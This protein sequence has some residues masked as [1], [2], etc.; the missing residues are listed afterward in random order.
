MTDILRQDIIEISF[1]VD[2]KPLQDIASEL[3]GLKK[4]LE[5]SIDTDAFDEMKESADE[6]NESIKDIKDTAKKA[7]SGLD[8]VNKAKFTKL[9]SGLQTIITKLTT[10]AKKA[11]GA[12]LTALK[13]VAG[14]SFK[15]VTAG[16]T[17]C[18]AAIGGLVTK[19]VQAY[20]DYEQLKGG[21]ETL[22]GAK[23]ATNVKEYAEIVGKSVDEV[24][25]EYKSLSDSEK[26]VFKNANNAYK[27]AGLSANAYME[28][29]TG[30]SASLLQ[31]VKGNT[32]EAVKLADIAISDMSDNANTFGTDIQSIQNAYQGFAKGN[33]TMLDNLKLGYGGTKEEMLRLVKDAGVVDKSVK[34]INDVSFDQIILAIN[35]TQESMGIAGTTAREASK[36]I[37]E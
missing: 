27:T 16:I 24:K 2:N 26:T 15:A 7:K 20:A 13:K 36:T 33:F 8:D 9:K 4:T 37:V 22:L 29:V 1:D 30:F 5:N 31:S 14:L 18:V 32:T 23:G 11:G 10:I 21:V 6:A 28:T 19:S 17:A 34:S 3:N 12:V 25:D 35:K